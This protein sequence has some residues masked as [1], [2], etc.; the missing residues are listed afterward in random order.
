MQPFNELAAVS[1]DSLGAAVRR[2]LPAAGAD[3][4]ATH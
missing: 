3:S 1:Y 4:A 2:T